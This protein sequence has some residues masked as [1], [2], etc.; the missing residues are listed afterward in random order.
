M[1]ILCVGTKYILEL[2]YVDLLKLY[3]IGFLD[4]DCNAWKRYILIYSIYNIYT[5]TRINSFMLDT[6]NDHIKHNKKAYSNLH[7][8]FIDPITCTVIDE[9][10]I[11]P[12]DIVMDKGIIYKHLMENNTNPFNRESLNID[13]LN[14]FNNKLENSLKKEQFKRDMLDFIYDYKK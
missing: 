7:E 12:P 5:D 4:Y 13:S 10:I 3:S 1:T 8:R 11:V 6:L 14:L 9:P 2:F